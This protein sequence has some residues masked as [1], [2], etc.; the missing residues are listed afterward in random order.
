MI[1]FPSFGSVKI[2]QAELSLR[3]ME[4]SKTEHPEDRER[5]EEKRIL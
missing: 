1:L 5:E 3:R 4:T 2:I